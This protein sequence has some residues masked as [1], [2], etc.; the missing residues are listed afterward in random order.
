MVWKTTP[1][2]CQIK[3]SSLKGYRKKKKKQKYQKGRGWGREREEAEKGK[4]EKIGV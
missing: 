1:E 3:T 2:S 4:E